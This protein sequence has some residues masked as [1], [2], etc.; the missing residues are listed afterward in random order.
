M[1]KLI[2]IDGKHQ[3]QFDFIFNSSHFRDFIKY[4]EDQTSDDF[5]NFL[6]LKKQFDGFQSGTN[7]TLIDTNLIVSFTSKDTFDKL[8]IVLNFASEYFTANY[9]IY[10]DFDREEVKQRIIC[11]TI[12]LKDYMTYFMKNHSD[13]LKYIRY[14]NYIRQG[15]NYIKFE[16]FEK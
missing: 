16:E 13:L 1:D 4:I 3:T 9:N 5:L 10:H 7:N 11:M 2:E 14:Q 12:K 15:N 6:L 8:T